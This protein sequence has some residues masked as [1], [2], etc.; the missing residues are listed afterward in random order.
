MGISNLFSFKSS[1][2][3]QELPD[4]FP[5]PIVQDDFVTTDVTNIYAKILTDVIERTDGIPDKYIPTLFDN[6][7]ASEHSYGLITMVSKAMVDKRD[8]FLVYDKPTNLLRKATND[9]ENRIKDDYKSQGQ[10]SVGT[11]VSFKN[12]KRSDMVKLYSALEYCAIASLNKNMNLSKA[13]QLKMNDMRGSVALNDKADIEA[14]AVAIATGLANGK[15]IIID[16]KD[17]IETASPDMTATDKSMQ[18]INQRRSFYLGLPESYVTGELSGGLGDS[19]QGDSKA[20]ERGLK[21]YYFSIVKPILESIF[22]IS[23]SF[24]SD[25]FDQIDTSLNVLKTFELTSDELI[26]QENKL[27]IVNKLFGFPVNTKGGEPDP[28]P[29]PEPVPSEDPAPIPQG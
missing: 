14:Q 11:F 22:G 8:L 18:F 19:G 1:G 28:V 16:G 3:S 20:I 21:N 9:E 10:S 7:L 17:V 6:C 24:K 13:I 2:S 4:I 26:S 29:E 12:Y 15:D 23:T 27:K 5:M 25:D